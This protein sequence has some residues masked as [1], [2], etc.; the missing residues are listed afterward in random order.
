M[1]KIF[2]GIIFSVI[3]NLA[4]GN[5][6]ELIN[7]KTWIAGQSFPTSQIVFYESIN[8]LRKAIFQINGSGHCAVYSAIYDIEI[9]KDTIILKDKMNLEKS[10]SKKSDN[11]KEPSIQTL[12]LIN[13]STLTSKDSDFEFRKAFNEPRICNWIEKYSGYNIIPIEK[14]KEI[15]IQEKMVYDSFNWGPNPENCGND[16]NPLLTSIEAIFLNEYLN[17]QVQS[18]GFDFTDKKILFVTGSGGSIIGTKSDYF[19]NIKKW[20]EIYKS[21]IATSL[22]VL[23][24]QEKLECGYDAILTYWVKIITP[25]VYKK[26]LL[27]A[28][29]KTDK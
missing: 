19:E 21:K 10:F 2:I 8:G 23:N 7:E 9:N 24:E 16:D 4:F 17:G 1:K 28:K 18:K 11:Q 3:T 26:V 12:Y 13:D 27:R 5:T 22:I 6:W 14:L 15:P 29:D 25:K 20:K